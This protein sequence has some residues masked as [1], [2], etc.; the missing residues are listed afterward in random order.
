MKQFF[1]GCL[2]ALIGVVIGF[3]ILS[4]VMFAAITKSISDSVDS[5]KEKPQ[6]EKVDKGPVL[7]IK[8]KGRIQDKEDE[9]DW[10]FDFADWMND[11]RLI[12]PEIVRSIDVAAKDKNIKAIYIRIYPFY[13]SISQLEEMRQ[14]L[15]NFKKSGKK[16]YVY[17][18]NYTQG[19]YYLASIA[20]TIA[21]HPQGYLLWK[22]LVSEISFYKKALEKLDI[23]VQVFRHGKFKSAAEP[24]ILDKMSEENRQQMRS[25][26]GVVW[27]DILNRIAESRKISENQLNQLANELSIKDAEAA[28]QYKMIDWLASEQA[29]DNFLEQYTGS[30]P[31]N[32]FVDYHQ[33]KQKSKEKYAKDSNKKIAVVYATG[34]IVDYV[35]NNNDEVIVPSKILKTLKDVEEDEDVKAVVIRVNSPGGSA[36]ASELIW[37]GI[38]QLKSKKPVI[39]SMSDMAASGGYYISSAADY[40][41]ANHNTITGSIGVFGILANVQNLME[42]DLGIYTD[43]VKTNQYAD[44]MSIL[45]PVQKKEYDVIMHSIEKIYDTFLSRVSKGRNLDKKYIDNI[46]QGRVWTGA[47]AVKLKL[48]DAIGTL[49]DA[50]AYAAKKTNITNYE[51]TVYPKPKNIYEKILEKFNN[52]I[53]NTLE[54]KVLKMQLGKYYKDVQIFKHSLQNHSVGYYALMPYLIEMY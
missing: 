44:F 48:A 42:K 50:I 28:L 27:R 10:S 17:A 31:K 40:I 8:L 14:S 5:I 24:F 43:T 29:I 37:Q 12:L 32:T 38:Q 20:D 51:V 18:D 2:G 4:I 16:I 3:I 7:K 9:T 26:I 1:G 52:D 49:E 23:Q 39:V 46:G 25:L 22:G 30:N 11:K 45:R 33:Y 13:A 47:D 6:Q 35:D 36:F 54:E 15:A 19:A 41:F 34:Q 21:L 53:D